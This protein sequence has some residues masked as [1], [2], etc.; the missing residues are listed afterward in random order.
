[1]KKTNIF[2]RLSLQFSTTFSELRSGAFA[3][4]ERHPKSF[5]FLMILLMA[6]SVV[7]CFTLLR[8]TGK[9]PPKT[10]ANGSMPFG[11]ARE[12]YGTAAKLATVIEMQ[13][14]LKGLLSKKQTSG[15]DS[16]RMIEMIQKINELQTDTPSYEK[17]KP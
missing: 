2:S 3:C 17:N 7:L 14:E 16:L 10:V 1:M 6:G 5:F 9:T 12:I 4:F 8:S 13:A 11:E 15:Q